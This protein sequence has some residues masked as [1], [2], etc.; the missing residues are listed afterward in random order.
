MTASGLCLSLRELSALPETGYGRCYR[1]AE[2]PNGQL[3][4]D[5]YPQFAGTFALALAVG[6]SVYDSHSQIPQLPQATL[7]SK[8]FSLCRLAQKVGQAF[9]LR[10]CQVIGLKAVLWGITV[11]SASF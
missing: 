9:A 11:T 3:N 2:Y 6:I 8:R 10:S 5:V 7:T 4:P 1:C